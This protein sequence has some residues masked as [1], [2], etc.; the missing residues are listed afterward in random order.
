MFYCC[1]FAL[2]IHGRKY[3]FGPR[4][5]FRAIL[6]KKLKKI[7]INQSMNENFKAGWIQGEGFIAFAIHTKLKP[8]LFMH[9]AH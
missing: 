7:K 4:E 3:G 9:L 2:G 5:G 6:F 1:I 8:L